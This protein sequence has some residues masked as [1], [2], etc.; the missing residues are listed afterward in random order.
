MSLNIV[1]PNAKI[2]ALKQS[3]SVSFVYVLELQFLVWSH[4]YSIRKGHEDIWITGY[5]L[6]IV[7]GWLLMLGI[8]PF[9]TYK[10]ELMFNLILAGKTCSF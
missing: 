2:H 6:K 8:F 3:A 9:V 1:Q 7:S 5:P 10:N 4:W